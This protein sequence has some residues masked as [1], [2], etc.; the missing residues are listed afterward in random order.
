M[1]NFRFSVTTSKQRILRS[2][3]IIGHSRG[4]P[5]AYHTAHSSLPTQAGSFEHKSGSAGTPPQ[6]SKLH[7]ITRLSALTLHTIE[8]SLRAKQESN[9]Q[10]RVY[11][12]QFHRAH[13]A[14]VVGLCAGVGLRNI[15]LQRRGLTCD[16]TTDTHAMRARRSH[17]TTTKTVKH[18]SEDAWPHRW[19][20][21]VRVE[22]ND[23]FGAAVGRR[24]LLLH[25]RRDEVKRR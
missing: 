22:V 3:F 14:A 17:A 24:R 5:R 16:T 20:D 25:L 15:D 18:K 13:S 10:R 1:R 12:R 9:R 23:P 19:L 8:L 4:G 11:H 7:L 2:A 21:Q 6:T